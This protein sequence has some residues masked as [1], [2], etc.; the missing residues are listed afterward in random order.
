MTIYYKQG[1]ILIRNAIPSDIVT[2]ERNLR[3][4][5]R[6]EL[7]AGKL[8]P[9]NALEL[10]FEHSTMR[11][12]TLVKDEIACVFGIAPDS[13]IGLSAS[14]WLIGTPLL[15]TIKK[16]FCKL[17]RLFI[18]RFLEDYPLLWN[19][20]DSRYLE[21]IKWLNFCGADFNGESVMVGDVP[22]YIFR[23]IKSRRVA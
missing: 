1:D 16:T 20:V 22:F 9:L 12:T 7:L 5:D 23:I 10:S 13:L 17:S 6:R 15:A 21:T 8:T 2:L 3:E 4:K 19:I 11:F 14:V 18:S